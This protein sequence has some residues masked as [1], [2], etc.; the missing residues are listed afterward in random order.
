MGSRAVDVPLL[1][2]R[3]RAALD[4]VLQVVEQMPAGAAGSRQ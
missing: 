2:R 1:A 3:R 4:V